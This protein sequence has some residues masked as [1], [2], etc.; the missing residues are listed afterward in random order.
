MFQ[1]HTTSRSGKSKICFQWE[2]TI[3]MCN[4][5]P[6]TKTRIKLTELKAEILHLQIEY[7]NSENVANVRVKERSVSLLCTASRRHKDINNKV[8]L[9]FPDVN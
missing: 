5:Q 2:F 4:R 1:L 3:C 7:V 8:F 9:N 6:L